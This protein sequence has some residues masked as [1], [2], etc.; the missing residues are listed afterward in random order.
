[1]SERLRIAQ[2]APIAGPV[3]PMRGSSIEQL[4]SLQTEELLARGHEVTL[5]AT[6]DSVT[7]ARLRSVYPQGFEHDHTLWNWE[8]HE[9]MHAGAAFDRARDFDVI[10]S[11]AYHAALPYTRL[12]DVPVIHT[13]HVVPDPDI[14][15][16]Y[17]RYPEAQLVAVSQYHRSAFERIDDVPVIYNG[18]DTV[19][20]PVNLEHGDYL[21]Y[22]G[23]MIRKKGPIDAIRIARKVGMRL[24]MAG[25]RGGDYFRDEV[26][27]LI[28]GRLVEYVGVVGREERNELLAGAAALLFPIADDEPFGLV[29]A[30]AMACGTPVAAFA[31]C[32]VPELIEPGVTGYYADDVD[33]LAALVPSILE[34]DRR[35]VRET[36]VARFDVHRMVDEYEAMY[37]QLVSGRR[38]GIHRLTGTSLPDV[39]LGAP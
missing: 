25:G 26:K 20:F 28:D 37:R 6:G 4:V 27:P 9:M 11:H 24:V 7:S 23:H 32:A 10:H 8:F 39:T 22:L 2:I 3:S 13:Y 14:C 18:I 15:R 19:A 17:A 29:V 5:F 1:M 12:V 31:R 35:R 33:S 34:L 16:L 36:A 21:F 38:C 30:E